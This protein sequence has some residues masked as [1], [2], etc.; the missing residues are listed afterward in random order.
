MDTMKLKPLA[1]AEFLLVTCMAFVLAMCLQELASGQEKLNPDAAARTA[2]AAQL[3]SEE[4][5]PVLPDDYA[6][7]DPPRI[8]AEWSQPPAAVKSDGEFVFYTSDGT[9]VCGPCNTQKSYLASGNLSF[10]YRTVGVPSGGKSPTGSVPLWQAP[11]GTLLSGA[12]SVSYLNQWAARHQ[13]A[14]SAS[15]S[16]DDLAVSVSVDASSPVAALQALAAHVQRHSLPASEAQPAQSWLPEIDVDVDDAVLRLL[17]SMLSADGLKTGG[18]SVKWP[19][20]VRSVSLSPAAELRFKKLVEID[21]ELTKVTVDGR[22]VTFAL[23]KF[24]DLTVRLK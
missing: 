7:N 13:P 22:K 10:S 4:D 6:K 17:D 18:L 15:T 16:P 12:S 2:A 20:G 21:V 8:S 24:P 23:S 14:S 5:A 1:I 19:A 11:D 9:W 3:A